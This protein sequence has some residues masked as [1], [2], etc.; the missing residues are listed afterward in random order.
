[1]KKYHNVTLTFDD[2]I[3]FLDNDKTN[4]NK[5]NLYKVSRAVAGIM[6]GNELHDTKQIS[7]ETVIKFCEYVG[8]WLLLTHS[9]ALKDAENILRRFGSIFIGIINHHYLHLHL[10][11]LNPQLGS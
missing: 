11:L 8:C 10:S 1:M 2:L 3:V 9:S 4:F 5:E 6:V 7:K